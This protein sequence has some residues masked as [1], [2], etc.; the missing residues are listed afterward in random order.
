MSQF[1]INKNGITADVGA[2]QFASLIKGL[3]PKN[4]IVNIF[5]DLACVRVNDNLVRLSPGVY[6]M[7]GF[8]VGVNPSTT[9]D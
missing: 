4:G 1:A 7:S 2:E 8:V 9:A 6:N 3:L 5:D